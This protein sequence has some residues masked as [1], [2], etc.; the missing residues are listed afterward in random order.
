[1]SKVKQTVIYVGL[2]D[3]DTH[4]QK[5]GVSRY[6]NVLKKVCKSYNVAFS[7]S[8]VDGG[9]FHEDGTYVDEKTLALTMMEVDRQVATEIAKDLCSF[10][11]QESVMMTEADAEVFF[12]KE[13]L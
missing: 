8:I 13:S 6:M 12:I 3:G 11:N 9:Y 5:Y 7:V 10:F 1:M 4:E 2:N